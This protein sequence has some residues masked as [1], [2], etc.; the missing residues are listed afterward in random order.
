MGL[1]KLECSRASVTVFELTF[2]GVHQEEL[3]AKRGEC[4]LIDRLRLWMPLLHIF[5]PMVHQILVICT[6]NYA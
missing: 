2:M 1:L 5:F 4:V 6:L 3:V